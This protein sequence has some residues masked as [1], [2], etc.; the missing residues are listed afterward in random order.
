[1]TAAAVAFTHTSAPRAHLD[2]I[3]VGVSQLDAGVAAF[4]RMTGVTA[5]RG[6]Q[7]P[8]RGTENALVSLGVGRYLELMAPRADAPA[9]PELERLRSLEQPAIIAWAVNVSDMAAARQAIAAAGVTLG[10]ET[11]GS[12]L[13]PSG[14]TLQWST[15]DVSAPQI[16]GA[17]FFIHWRGATE[18]PSITSPTGCTLAALQIEDPAAADLS[19]ALHALRVSGVTVRRG[20]PRIIAAL[21]CPLGTVEIGSR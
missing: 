6:G 2:H 19:R 21:K 7:H 9:S 15:A 12:R 16:S 13:T 1:M 4:E 3:V 14:A 18:H 8:G 17:P 10:D 5:V 20:N 11:P